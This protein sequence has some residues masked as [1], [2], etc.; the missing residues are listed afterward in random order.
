[1]KNIKKFIILMISLIIVGVVASKVI[2][3]LESDKLGANERNIYNNEEK[4][5]SE[6]DS[7]SYLRKK[8]KD[9]ENSINFK[10]VE[11]TG[12]DTA[13]DITCDKEI[14]VNLEYESEI[15]KGEF[16]VLLI[17]SNNE[18]V[19]ILE[20][21]NKGNNNIK[22]PTG[23]S[24]IRIVGNKSTGNLKINITSTNDMEIKVGDL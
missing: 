7:Y 3:I 11:F 19:N 18:I 15:L 22:I 9:E 23:D 8:L 24:K 17:T 5:L 14:F 13:Y 1:M 10:F 6:R 12:I 2:I 20:G 16:K 21:S 4:I